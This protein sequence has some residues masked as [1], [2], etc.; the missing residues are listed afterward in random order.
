MYNG[1]KAKFTQNEK[2]KRLL[3]STQ[4]KILI[5]DTNSDYYWGCGK[6]KTGKNMLGILLM[7]LREEL[8]PM[9]ENI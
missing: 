7:K 5:E 3:L 9:S 2:I 8:M 1:L 4:D 6:N